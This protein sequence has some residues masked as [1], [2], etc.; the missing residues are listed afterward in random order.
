MCETKV[1]FHMNSLCDKMFVNISIDSDDDGP[2]RTYFSC[3]LEVSRYDGEEFTIF[4]ERCVTKIEEWFTE[5][6][7]GM[8]RLT[9]YCTS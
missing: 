3:A 4:A 8:D 2:A 9:E 7:E 6:H 1:R 5:Y